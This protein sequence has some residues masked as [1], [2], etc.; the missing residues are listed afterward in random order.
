MHVVVFPIYTILIVFLKID[1][2]LRLYY[3]FYNICKKITACIINIIIMYN[4]GIIMNNI[5]QNKINNIVLN[6]SHCMIYK[7]YTISFY[8]V[9]FDF[10]YVFKIISLSIS[11]NFLM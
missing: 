11:I 6:N 4:Y 3:I 1:I 9:F 5:I 2:I 7:S 8:F 10:F